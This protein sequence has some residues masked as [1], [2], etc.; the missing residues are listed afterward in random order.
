MPLVAPF[1]AA[2]TSQSPTVAAQRSISAKKVQSAIVVPSSISGH[3]SDADCENDMDWNKQQEVSNQNLGY[4]LSE[5]PQPDAPMRRVYSHTK[6]IAPFHDM[7]NSNG[8]RGIR[9]WRNFRGQHKRSSWSS[10][11]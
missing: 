4:R 11:K 9:G 10:D 3:Q 5:Y 7:T 8:R 6:P 1:S 2:I